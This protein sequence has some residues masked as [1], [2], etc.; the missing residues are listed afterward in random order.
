MEATEFSNK[1]LLLGHTDERA[2]V[3][4]GRISGAGMYG[5]VLACVNK[6]ILRFIDTDLSGKIGRVVAEIPL[7]KAQIIKSSSFIFHPLLRI[8]YSGITY[9]LENFA[10][11]KEFIAVVKEENA[12]D[13]S[14]EE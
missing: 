2:A 5:M 11:A 10:R 1:L 3:V 8:R 12:A 13:S 9:D 7:K 4:T 14:S 6:D